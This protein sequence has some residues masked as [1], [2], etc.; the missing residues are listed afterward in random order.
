LK[1]NLLLK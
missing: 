1:Q